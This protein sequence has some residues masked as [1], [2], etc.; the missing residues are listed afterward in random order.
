MIITLLDSA[1]LGSDIVTGI[2]GEFGTFRDFA[3]TADDEI[4]DR[5]AQS[6]IVVTNKI[7]LDAGRLE[8]AQSLKLICLTATGV[9]NIDL[10]AAKR[11]NI[12]VTN[13]A[14]YSTASVAQHTIGMTLSL[15]EHLHYY[16]GYVKSGAYAGNTMFTHL[17]RTFWELDG[18]RWGIIGLGAIG[19]AVAR[20]A[21]S[22]GCTVTYYSTSGRNNDAEYARQSL[23]DLLRDS[24][25]VS[26]HAP[27]NDHTRGL[28]GSAELSRMKPDSILVNVGRGGIVDE[29]DLA[30]ALRK[31]VL[32]AAALDVFAQEPINPDN[33]LLASDLQE[34]LLLTPHIAWASIEA[35]TRVIQEVAANI[36]AFLAGEQR[37]RIV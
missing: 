31:G 20:V 1:T 36:R 7:I 11:Q 14:G 2:L 26:V 34:K 22:L 25:I 23:D 37:N 5:I 28:I 21:G 30:D 27:M 33:P 4:H 15:L 8:A 24:D 18:K 10:E 32:R 12:A 16:D 19:R 35:R 6:E 29:G 13:V 9:N 3:A 17:S